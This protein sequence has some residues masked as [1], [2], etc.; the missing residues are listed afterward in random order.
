MNI[1][2]P[3]VEKPCEVIIYN[4]WTL[5]TGIFI[6]LFVTSFLFWWFYLKQRNDP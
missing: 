3:A 2:I 6:G 1:T 4:E 5:V